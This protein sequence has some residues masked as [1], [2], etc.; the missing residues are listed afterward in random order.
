M[1]FNL[2]DTLF[3]DLDGYDLKFNFHD[4]IKTLL[5]SLVIVNE[6]ILKSYVKK[7]LRNVYGLIPDEVTLC[8]NTQYR[9]VQKI[10]RFSH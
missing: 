2:Q 6:L 5:L 4:M 9:I 3:K 8:S 7:G 10:S 1:L